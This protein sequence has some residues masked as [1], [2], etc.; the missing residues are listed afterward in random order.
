M[1]YQLVTPEHLH[2]F[3]D[4]LA[5]EYR[6]TGR[7]YLVGGTGLLYQGLKSVTKDV[8]LSTQLPSSDQDAFTRIL[9][10][11]SNDMQIAIEEVSPADFIPCHK[12]PSS[13]TAFWAARVSW[14]SLPLTLS[15]QL[16]PSSHVAASLILSMSLRSSRQDSFVLIR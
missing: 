2:R 5:R 12:E 3:L 8:D 9:R 7:I 15:R 14:T 11:L 10:R 13:V 16:W 4:R 1:P 6:R